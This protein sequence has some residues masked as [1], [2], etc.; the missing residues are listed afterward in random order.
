MSFE[1]IVREN[2]VLVSEGI[3]RSK[4][5]PIEAV[6]IRGRTRRRNRWVGTASIILVVVA[7]ILLVSNAQSGGV[8]LADGELLVSLNP[9]IVQ[10]SESVPP[11][12]DISELGPQAPLAPSTDTTRI[13]ALA[14]RGDRDIVRITILGE[15]PEGHLALVVNSED[16]AESHSEQFHYRCLTTELGGGCNGTQLENMAAYPDGYLPGHPGGAPTI[17]VGGEGF[18]GWEVPPETSVVTIEHNGDL[19]WQRPIADVAVFTTNLQQ[20]DRLVLTALDF[21]GNYLDR[22]NWKINLSE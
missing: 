19:R 6:K 5:L 14:S 2:L 15:T 22:I 4:A 10:G 20:G 16:R 17:A 8:P 21:K 9:P 11:Q 13:L 18:V 3:P 1:E 7:G 12:F